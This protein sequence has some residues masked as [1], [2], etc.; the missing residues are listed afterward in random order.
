MH[1]KR[2]YIYS[3]SSPVQPCMHADIQD[4]RGR[5]ASIVARK[6]R[7][8]TLADYVDRFQPGPRGELAIIW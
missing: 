5:S 3:L 8:P 4:K 2:T 6:Y 1:I 7:H